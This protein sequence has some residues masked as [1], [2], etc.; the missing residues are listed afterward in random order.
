M[1]EWLFQAHSAVNAE[2]DALGRQRDTLRAA[3]ERFTEAFFL[4]IAKADPRPQ[5]VVAIEGGRVRVYTVGNGV[6][7]PVPVEHVAVIGSPVGTECGD[8]DDNDE[9]VG[10]GI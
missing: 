1:S 9:M 8:K 2:A 7:N 4:S 5:V 3:W 10:E 6:L